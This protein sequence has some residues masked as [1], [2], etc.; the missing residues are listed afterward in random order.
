MRPAPHLSLCC[1]RHEVT[2]IQLVVA[3]ALPMIPQLPQ[4]TI[5]TLY[6]VSYTANV[7]QHIKAPDSICNT[8]T[9]AIHPL[10]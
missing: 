3:S 1:Q 6:T 9:T 4:Q 7:L 5:A 2:F 10:F 8:A